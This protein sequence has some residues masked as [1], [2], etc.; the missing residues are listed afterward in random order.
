[1]GLRDLER[2][3]DTSRIRGIRVIIRFRGVKNQIV[4]DG[5]IKATDMYG[6]KVPWSQAFQQPP[7][8][9]LNTYSI[10][11]I[12]VMC[13]DNVVASYSS[14]SELMRHI[15]EYECRG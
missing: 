9:V 4:I 8:V 5:E 11:R 2:V 7:H 6:V 1:M 15:N 3:I 10:E 14:F 13:G 12:Y